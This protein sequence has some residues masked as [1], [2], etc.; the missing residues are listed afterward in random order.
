MAR[1][2][3]R[4]KRNVS[5]GK[6]LNIP[7]PPLKPLPPIPRDEPSVKY[8][9]PTTTGITTKHA[10]RNSTRT[11]QKSDFNLCCVWEFNHHYFKTFSAIMKML[12]IATLLSIIS[13]LA[14]TSYSNEN[15]VINGVTAPFHVVMLLSVISMFV[16]LAIFIIMSMGLHYTSYAG[17][18]WANVDFYS[19]LYHIIGLLIAAILQSSNALGE[20]LKT[21][22]YTGW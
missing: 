7:R 1:S 3:V 16:I 13:V 2:H 9:R 15:L 6:K 10:I 17:I 8:Q 5:F 22:Y 19:N 14:T 4:R 18:N 11:Y 20:F 12:E 21:S